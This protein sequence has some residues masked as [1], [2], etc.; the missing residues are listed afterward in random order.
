MRF[1]KG[2]KVISFYGGPGSGKS[3]M[4]ATVFAELKRQRVNVE[5]IT[6]VAKELSYERRMDLLGYQDAILARQI[7]KMT[8]PYGHVDVIVTDSPILMSHV[9]ASKDYPE[10]FYDWVDHA[11]NSFENIDIFLDRVVPFSE[12]GRHHNEEEAGIISSFMKKTVLHRSD[13]VLLT[14]GHSDNVEEIL[15]Y[16][17]ERL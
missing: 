10:C 4:A 5:L 15:A 9:Y 3:T 7:R 6:E 13:Q 1:H 11:Y 8:I 2:M 14:Q 12:E 17:K 16:I